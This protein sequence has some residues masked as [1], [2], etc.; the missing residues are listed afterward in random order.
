VLKAEISEGSGVPGTVLD[1]ALAVACGQG[2]VRLLVLQREG[3]SP[4]S[5]PD[6]LRGL[7]V[8]PGTRLAPGLD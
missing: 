8:R 1:N 3:K 6:F 7:A 4:A 5:A 2:A